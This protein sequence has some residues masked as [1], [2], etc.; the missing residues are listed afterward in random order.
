M[1]PDDAGCRQWST[2]GRNERAT[3][4]K[5]K[6]HGLI[7]RYNLA[8]IHS[9]AWAKH[10]NAD[11]ILNKTGQRLAV[12]FDALDMK[13]AVELEDDRPRRFQRHKSY[14]STRPQYMLV[15]NKLGFNAVVS[16]IEAC[17]G[18][19]RRRLLRGRRQGESQKR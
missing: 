2:L 13:R 14:V 18:L 10:A 9:H 4:A 5:P 7:C 3:P 1:S 17:R 11:R 16:D 15:R 8:Q 6:G 12:A 19:L